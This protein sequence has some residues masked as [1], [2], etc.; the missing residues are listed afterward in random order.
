VMLFPISEGQ[1]ESICS[2]DF[3]PDGDYEVEYHRLFLGLGRI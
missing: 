3:Q 1:V 2:L